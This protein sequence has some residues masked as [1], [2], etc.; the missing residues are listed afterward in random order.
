MASWTNDPSPSP[1]RLAFATRLLILDALFR[2]AFYPGDHP[3][4]DY[5]PGGGGWRVQKTSF[6]LKEVKRLEFDGG[7]GR[8]EVAKFHLEEGDIFKR[9]GHPPLGSSQGLE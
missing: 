2:M 3:R 1:L 4:P 6:D 7:L 5:L 8:G 9:L